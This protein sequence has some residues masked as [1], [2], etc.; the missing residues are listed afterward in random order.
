MNQLQSSSIKKIQMVGRRGVAQVQFTT[1]ELREL[2][3]K[4]NGIDSFVNR[5]EFDMGFNAI[6]KETLW[7]SFNP[8]EAR[9]LEKI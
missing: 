2:T 6:N 7:R 8:N 5:S 1:K 3:N 9:T 4:I